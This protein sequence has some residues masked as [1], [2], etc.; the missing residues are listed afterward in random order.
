MNCIKQTTHHWAPLSWIRCLL[1]AGIGIGVALAPHATSQPAEQP[2]AAS[3][4]TQTLAATQ[5]ALKPLVGT[6]TL[7]TVVLKTAGAQDN[8][9][10][11]VE[12]APD[13]FAFITSNG[14]RQAYPYNLVQ[15]VRVQ[16][17]R[18][19]VQKFTFD[20]GLALRGVEQ[21]VITRAI[22]RTREVFQSANDNQSIK[23]NAAA[24]MAADGDEAGSTYLRQLAATNNIDVALEA[25]TYLYLAG[26]GASVDPTLVERALLSGNRK[27]RITAAQLAGL[28]QLSSTVPTLRMMSSD[29]SADLSAPAIKALG[30][31]QDTNSVPAMAEAL[32][33]LNNEK[34]EAAVDALSRIG[35][36]DVIDRVKQSLNSV[37][38]QIWLR[39]VR[40]LYRLDDPLGKELLSEAMETPGFD[41]E[42]ALDLTRDGD[43]GASEYL[44][45]AM[46]ER[47]DPNEENLIYKARAAAALVE[48]DYPPAV[49]ELS[50][51]LRL[52]ETD[53]LALGADAEQAK[54][55]IVKTVR[56]FAANRI[57]ELGYPN[58]MTILQPPIESIDAETALAA[59]SAALA[60]ADSEFKER[61]IE[62]KEW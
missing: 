61:L 8:N 39:H 33:G 10:R 12:A 25:A 11:I 30:R 50:R 53:V 9:L 56:I 54:Q 45:V 52:Q 20:S 17:G 7:V 24:I 47:N 29:R 59:S 22:Q 1:V 3:G 60:I 6:E 14:D 16:A 37:K 57:A 26:D 58:L 62:L 35:G 15:E 27:H 18:M 13:Y 42:A 51:L 32:A 43:W 4:Y 55:A 48:A 49:S 19:D 46:T 40:V 5:S 23:M 31:L 41:R 44:R 34:G 28:L 36:A 38:G 21:E 2:A